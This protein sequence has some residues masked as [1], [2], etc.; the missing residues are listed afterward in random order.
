MNRRDFLEASAAGFALAATQAGAG[1]ATQAGAQPA[2]QEGAQPAARPPRVGLIGCG[3]Y[4]K[5]D[6]LRLLQ[7]APVEVTALCD[8]D[9]RMLGA[10]A[11]TVA[12]RQ[13]SRQRPRT[14][15]DYREMLRPR[16]LD[17]V[18]IATPDHWHALPMIAAV[19]AGADVY[20]QKPISVD[21]VEGQAMVAA[22]RRHNKVVQVGTQR[23]STPHIMDARDRVIRAGLLGQVKHVEIYCYYHMRARGNPPDTTPPDYLNYEMWTGPAPMRPYN[24]LVHPRS[25]RAFMEYGNGIVG[26]MCIH[27]LDMVRWLLD[28]GW[29]RRVSSSG[30]I[31]VDRNSK[32]NITDTQVATFDY[33]DRQ[34]V[35]QHRTWGQ[36]TDPDYPWGATL[37]GDRG[38]LKVSVHRYDFTPAQGERIHRD[39]VME[40]DQYPEDRTERDLEQHVAPAI[41]VHMRN[42]LEAIRTR[43]R[44][45]ADIEQGHI[46]TASCILA[47]MA[48]RL[49]RT[50]A[51]D[52]ERQRVI[53]D[54]EANRLLRRPYRM[55]WVHPEA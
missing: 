22:A 17:I 21:I 13:R 25:W 37:Y 31:L 39:V 44:P 6:L 19:E 29:P 51:W 55:P 46:S 14:F 10:A 50:L 8:V 23:R 47:N 32:A 35:W 42:F 11:D 48:Q 28:L 41:R 7:V 26:D 34:V 5:C 33:G 16:D 49:N 12:A 30:G 2:R 45:V 52:A 1:A 20:V 53:N 54:D 38:T 3:W 24:S 4:G 27:M 36:A 40:L 15:G 18:L 9:S 43:G